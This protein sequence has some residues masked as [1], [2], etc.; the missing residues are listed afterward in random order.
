MSG[1]LT[2]GLKEIRDHVRD[3]R[4]LASAAMYSL[5][6]PIVLLL[7]SQSPAAARGGS[8][9]LL[10]MMSV[11]ALVSA[12]SGGMYIAL[13]TTA[14]ERERGSLVPL[15]LNPV[16]RLHVIL[17]KWLAV[18][19]FTL[20]GLLL[21]LVG[22]TAVFEWGGIN[23]SSQTTAVV[24]LWIGCGLIPLA[25]LGAALDL[26]TGAASK[27]LKDAQARLSTVMFAPMIVGMFLVFFPEWIGRAWFVLPVIGQQAL[28]GAGLRG[29]AVP[30]WQAV[31]LGGLTLALTALTLAAAGRAMN[32]DQNF[33][34]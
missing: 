10:S 30:V 21:T 29:E 33:A 17:G 32:R 27:T 5:M 7:V 19:V 15:M 16:A 11:F 22:F 9:V 20:A 25:L 14:G 18:A 2:I 26:L 23:P 3:R 1:W 24:L 6:G 4:S 13:D 28:I 31:L 8:S 12:F 34:S